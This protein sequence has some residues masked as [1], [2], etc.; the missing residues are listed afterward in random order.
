MLAMALTAVLAACV[1]IAPAHAKHKSNVTTAVSTE[2]TDS[3]ESACSS[4]QTTFGPDYGCTTQTTCTQKAICGAYTWQYENTYYLVED[5]EASL[6]EPFTGLPR[7]NL[8]TNEEYTGQLVIDDDYAYSLGSQ[9]L[10]GLVI[11]VLLFVSMILVAFFY[12]LSSCCKCCGLCQCCFRPTP[13]TRKSLH[14]A[15]GIQ[16]VFVLMA[17]AG[18]LMIYIR[19]PDL[20]DGVLTIANGLV[21]STDNLVA[22]VNAISKAISGLSTDDT[23]VDSGLSDLTNATTTVQD[24]I[25]STK[26][27]LE[28]YVDQIQLGADIMAGVILGVA[29][30]TMA[31]SIL[32][33]WRLLSLFAVITSLI[34]ILSWIVVG[35]LAAVGVFLADFCYTGEQYVINPNLVDISKDIPCTNAQDVVD[36]G[37]SFRQLI[38]NIV[39]NANDLVAVWN[40]ANSASAKNYICLPYQMQ[41]VETLCGTAAET[42]AGTFTSPYWDDEYSNYV[43]EAYGKDQLSGVSVVYPPW[44]TLNCASG[45]S[46]SGYTNY[47]ATYTFAGTGSGAY[48]TITGIKHKYLLSENLAAAYTGI[49]PSD[50]TLLADLSALNAVVPTFED[51]LKCTFISDM[52]ES[53]NAGC[54]DTALAIEDMWKGFVV[55]SVAY[56][57]LW[58]TMLVTLGRMSNV[59]LMIDGG[60][61]DAKKAG[62]V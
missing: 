47:S 16:L 34:L 22:D 52:F 29:F 23:S 53:I 45:S 21:N 7:V 56:L 38:N 43:C 6:P 51:I 30:L 41:K 8:R 5:N 57:C 25:K 26:D 24:T 36:F 10:P 49:F 3:N 31:L 11:A 2:P 13:Y 60:R 14:L 4:S 54:A 9:A 42:E 37:N 1:A 62:L 19:S 44:D 15:K 17:A 27:T 48:P 35:V 61:F 40:T 46:G 28:K 39:T 33:F 12:L 55:I 50:N 58:I 32:N 18:C 59:D 20:T